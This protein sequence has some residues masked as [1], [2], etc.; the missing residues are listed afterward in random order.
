MKN[1]G[2]G[3]CVTRV[4]LGIIGSVRRQA[5]EIPVKRCGTGVMLGQTK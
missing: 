3:G 5:Q 2:F 4:S 1:C